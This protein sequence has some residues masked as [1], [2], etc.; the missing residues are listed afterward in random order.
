MICKAFPYDAIR[1]R[2]K[3]SFIYSDASEF[4]V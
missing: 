4:G 3:A 1:Q 2:L